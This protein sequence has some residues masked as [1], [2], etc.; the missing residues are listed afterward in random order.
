VNAP[1]APR[2][3]SSPSGGDA[4]IA[5]PTFTRT[6][7]TARIGGVATRR[8]ARFTSQGAR[9]TRLE[10]PAVIADRYEVEGV[11]S[12]AGGQGTIYHAR[13]ARLAGR[14]CLIKA[15]RHAPLAIERAIEGSPEEVLRARA[16]LERECG[17]LVTMQQ[18]GE[19]RVPNLLRLEHD[20]FPGLLHHTRNPQREHLL[21]EPYMVMQHVPG[22]TLK[23]LLGEVAEG[24]LHGGRESRRWW[25]VALQL[26]RELASILKVLHGTDV[27]VDGDGTRARRGF[28]YGDLKPDNCIVTSGEFVTLIDFGGVRSYWRGVDEPDD[29]PWRSEDDPVF[30]AGYVAPEMADANWVGELDPRVDVYSAGALLW[31]MLTGHSPTRLEPSPSPVLSADDVRLP[32]RLPRYLRE[33]LRGAL[34]RDRERRTANAEMLK[35]QCIDALQKLAKGE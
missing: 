9:A 32:Q 34:E 24:R 11:L 33:L 20:I 21:E 22:V 12:D 23:A 28:F 3:T 26:T 7:V 15:L 10:I 1:N 14:R 35:K 29:A 6:E 18:R 31:H 16:G 4:S 5:D 17:F 13:D 19:G 30:T 25:R 2:A 27:V 8:I